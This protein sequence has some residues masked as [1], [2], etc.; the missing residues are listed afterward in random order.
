MKIVKELKKQEGANDL[1]NDYRMLKAIKAGNYTMSVQ[2]STGHYCFPRE[3]KPIENY[4]AMELAI[5]NKKKGWL[6]VTKSSVLKKFPRYN[7]LLERADDVNSSCPVF[8]Y[9]SIGLLN[10]LYVYLKGE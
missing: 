2:G 7:E 1:A 4:S 8:G 3:T 10:D 5:F 6:H 9:V